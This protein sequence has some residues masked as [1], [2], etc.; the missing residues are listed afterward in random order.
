M[1]GILKFNL[2]EENSEFNDAVN[3]W[4]WRMSMNELDEWIRGEE[5]YGDGIKDGEQ[6][7]DKI[8]E[9]LSENNLDLYNE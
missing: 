7:R 2:P 9:I 5:K 3:G 6:V 1:T 8:R 4:K